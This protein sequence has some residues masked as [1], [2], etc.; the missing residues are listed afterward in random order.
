MLGDFQHDVDNAGLDTLEGMRT[1][2]A[3]ASAGSFTAAAE[4]LGRSTALVSKYVRQLED[5]L[6]VRLLERTT[7]SL[8]LTEIGRAYLLESWRWPAPVSA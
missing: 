2:V 5:R 8:R 3:L 7:R 6:H 4:E 1:F